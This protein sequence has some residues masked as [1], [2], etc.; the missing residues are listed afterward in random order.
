MKDVLIRKKAD[1]K[2]AKFAIKS[3]L[4]ITGKDKNNELFDGKY[5][6]KNNVQSRINYF[7]SFIKK[8]LD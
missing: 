7:D 2:K 1:I 5:N 3:E 4:I 8:F 6:S